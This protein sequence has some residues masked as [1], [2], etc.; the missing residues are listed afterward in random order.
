MLLDDSAETHVRIVYDASVAGAMIYIR[1]FE[2]NKHVAPD[3][4]HSMYVLH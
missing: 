2:P 4:S 1:T 3:L